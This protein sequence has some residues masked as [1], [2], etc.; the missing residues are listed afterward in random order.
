MVVTDRRFI[1][2]DRGL[3]QK[4]FVAAGE[5]MA[6]AY[7]A[8]HDLD[9]IAGK[10]GSI[11]IPFTDVRCVRIKIYR[12]SCSIRIEYSYLLAEKKLEV[13]IPSSPT[14]ISLRMSNNTVP[15]IIREVF[16]DSSLDTSKGIRALN[17]LYYRALAEKLKGALPVGIV[18]ASEWPKKRV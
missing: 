4:G 11:M 2:P 10:E 8:Y 18:T 3:A 7:S 9:A 1:F 16:G 6:T 12:L 14:E 5:Q 15:S 13:S 17:A